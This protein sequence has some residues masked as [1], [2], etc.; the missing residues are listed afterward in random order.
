V[1]IRAGEKDAAYET[2][3]E[4]SFAG[5]PISEVMDLF[6]QAGREA[7]ARHKRLGLPIVTWRDGRVVEIPPEEIVV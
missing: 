5:I 7:L 4:P 2:G 3:V 1:K 6:D